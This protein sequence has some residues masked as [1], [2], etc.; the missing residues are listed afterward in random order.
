M[1][2]FLS[3]LTSQS[4]L[5]FPL[6]FPV[7]SFWKQTYL[8]KIQLQGELDLEYVTLWHSNEVRQGTSSP[9]LCSQAT[10]TM[11]PPLGKLCMPSVPSRSTMTARRHVHTA[12][13]L[14]FFLMPGTTAS[15]ALPQWEV[16]KV[17]SLAPQCYTGKVL[18]PKGHLECCQ[19]CALHPLGKAWG[20]KGFPAGTLLSR[21]V[22]ATEHQ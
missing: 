7:F 1:L 15:S 10:E 8:P 11:S 4:Q 16:S 18:S 6:L 5:E 21:A 2:L 19:G 14:C 20:G 12:F 3:V 13:I 17:C 9:Q 22:R